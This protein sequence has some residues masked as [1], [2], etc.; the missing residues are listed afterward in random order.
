MF[1]RLRRP[2]PPPIHAIPPAPALNEEHQAAAILAA[3]EG[4]PPP[5]QVRLSPL[6]EQTLAGIRLA[7]HRH[8][9]KEL[10][11]AVDHSMHASEAMAAAAMIHGEVRETAQRSAAIVSTLGSMSNAID[12]LDALGRETVAVMTG[13]GKAMDQCTAATSTSVRACQQIGD[14]FRNMGGAVDELSAAAQEIGEFVTT[15]NAIAGQ[16]NLLALN[17]T[18]EAARAGEA[19]KGFAVVAGEV[20]TL[21]AQT[22]RATDDIRARIERL[23]GQVVQVVAGITNSQTQVEQAMASTRE[24]EA[25]IDSIRT[26]LEDN[27]CNMSSLSGVLHGEA[28]SA[29]RVTTAATEIERHARTASGH[30]DA[31]LGAVGAS[32]K[33]INT[34]FEELDRRSIPGYVL[35]RAKSDHLLWKKRLAEV[36]A[37]RQSLS[38]DELADHRQCRLGKWYSSVQDPAIRNHPAFAALLA[39]HEAVHVNGRE[40]ARLCGAGDAEGARAA[41]ARMETASKGV[42]DALQSLINAQRE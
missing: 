8:A 22:Q 5:E 20:K 24:V 31:V 28:E 26:M 37:G 10:E 13:A 7:G 32:E 2:P 6:M 25:A 39:P 12:K 1:A 3:F 19:G 16:T 27:V 18:I 33:V 42:L 36:M 21:A 35:F 4:K 38:P 40:V 23:T 14:S 11:N 15:I 29:A 9:R 41:F 34:Q 17:A 30:A